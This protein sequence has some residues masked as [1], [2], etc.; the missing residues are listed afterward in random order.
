MFYFIF[1]EFCYFG[2]FSCQFVYFNGKFV[3]NIG[4]DIDDIEQY[5]FYCKVMFF[6]FV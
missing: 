5:L 4:V 3:V 6:N 1:V 2:E